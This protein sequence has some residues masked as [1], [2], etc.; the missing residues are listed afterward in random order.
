M[1]RGMVVVRCAEED[2]IG[3]LTRLRV[4]FL[5]ESRGLSPEQLPGGFAE[6]TEEF[7]RRHHQA[8]TT[9]SW[10]AEEEGHCLGIVTM[11]VLDMPPH[12][13]VA[14]SLEGFVVNMYVPGAARHRGIG[15]QL[16][17]ACLDGAREMGIRKLMLYATPDGRPLYDTL[18]FAPGPAFMDLRLSIPAP[19]P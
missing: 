19:G 1:L 14:E 8:G 5:A 13:L 7:F 9:R 4:D 15:R 11:V 17:D 10:L 12:P 16:M 6:A 18:G 3:A 2:D